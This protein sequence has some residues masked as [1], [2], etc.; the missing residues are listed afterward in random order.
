MA[1]LT[2]HKAFLGRQELCARPACPR[3]QRAVAARA[4]RQG[5][6]LPGIG[7][8]KW[9]DG[10]LPGDRGFGEHPCAV[11]PS[12]AKHRLVAVLTQAPADPLGLATDK[13]RLEW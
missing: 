12:K 2:L 3:R 5:L 6:W 7:A 8:P 9:L 1:N 13:E 4:D 10:S 11:R